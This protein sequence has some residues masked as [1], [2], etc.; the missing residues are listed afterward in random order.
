ML[1]WINPYTAE[2]LPTTSPTRFTGWT[3]TL[4]L[5]AAVVVNL[6]YVFFLLDDWSFDGLQYVSGRGIISL[7]LLS[8]LAMFY[9][10]YAGIRAGSATLKAALTSVTEAQI[11]D[12]NVIHRKARLKVWRLTVT[13]V[14]WR[15]AVLLLIVLELRE[16]MMPGTMLAATLQSP[17]LQS[18]LPMTI[19][20]VM[21]V[22]AA[23]IY[24]IEPIWRLRLTT[25]FGMWAALRNR[26]TESNAYLSRNFGWQL[27]YWL[28]L[29]ILLIALTGFARQIV[30]P[31][32]FISQRDVW[33]WALIVGVTTIA[34][35][36]YNGRVTQR[37]LRQ[38]QQLLTNLPHQE[39]T[40]DPAHQEW[41]LQTS[42]WQGYSFWQRFFTWSGLIGLMHSDNPLFIME[43]RT[44]KHGGTTKGL[45]HWTQRILVRMVLV[46]GILG[47]CLLLVVWNNYQQSLSYYPTGYN[48]HFVQGVVFNFLG[49][50]VLGLG[51]LSILANGLLDFS[52]IGAGLNSINRDMVA[53]RWDL[54]RLTLLPE[55]QILI[56]KHRI[57]QLRAWRLLIWILGMRVLSVIL[58]FIGILIVDP[59]S[60]TSAVEQ[61][62][63]EFSRRPISATVLALV[64]LIF[65]TAYLLEPF[66]RQQA[67][68]AVGL[69]VS[70]GRNTING[71]LTG[72]GA[73]VG[74]W[75]SQAFIIYLLVLG[76]SVVNNWVFTAFYGSYP[77][78][79]SRTPEEYE[80]LAVFQMGM[81]LLACFITAAV[82]FLYYSVLQRLNLRIMQR[83]AFAE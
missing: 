29:Y 10:D 76:M 13:L 27:A 80:M 40:L 17:L 21:T 74:V 7:I 3:L 67:M 38:S 11:P 71:L 62:F 81:L 26:D 79:T 46:F 44:L 20:I 83:R 56:A 66:W 50:S 60:S 31:L 32:S 75:I 78:Y 72:L 18:P 12:L 34:L 4:V 53:G 9:A 30:P 19:M 28:G 69:A 82:I 22:L 6:V 54:M 16:Q 52:S 23:G 25:T 64:L 49:I 1:H 48:Y 63:R 68:T 65:V 58:T 47:C 35:V 77:N 73:I 42:G 14:G 70:A 51:G 36:L 59:Y 57:T 45:Q 55:K 24:L 61:M 43:A 37:Y 8:V 5:R 39:E 41:L 33:V 2:V 15:L